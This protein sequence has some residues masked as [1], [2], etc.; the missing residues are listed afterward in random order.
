MAAPSSSSGSS[1]TS[2]PDFA[3]PSCPWAT[4]VVP[5]CGHLPTSALT[6]VEF[7][8]LFGRDPTGPDTCNPAAEADAPQE[9]IEDSDAEPQPR[10]SDIVDTPAKRRRS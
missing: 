6:A 10:D 1:S 7:K 5:P 2:T 9:E 8:W 3:V 4:T